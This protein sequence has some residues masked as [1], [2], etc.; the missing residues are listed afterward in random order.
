MILDLRGNGGG[1]VET[2]KR[3]TSNVFT[4][5]VKISETTGRKKSEPTLAKS[6]GSEAFQGKI[7]VL[8]DAESGS[9]SEVFARVIQ[10][11]K[12]GTVIGDVSAGAV[13]ESIYHAQEMGTESIVPFGISIT[14]ADVIMSDGKSLE[15][16]GV[17]PDETIIPTAADL[18]ARRDPVIARA[19]ELL[20]GKI[21]PEAA[22]QLFKYYWNK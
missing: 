15:H 5:D 16:I 6:R 19:V 2:L 13:M 11:E 18:A 9:A 8:I 10:L 12:R 17:V 1:Y 20:G 7:V 4:T 14:N 3:L 21:T 22:G